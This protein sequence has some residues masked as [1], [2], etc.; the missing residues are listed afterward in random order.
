MNR[1]L[2]SG[3]GRD[4][5][6]PTNEDIPGPG[7][8]DINEN[9][10]NPYKNYGFITKTDRFKK[11]STLFTAYI[12]LIH[13]MHLNLS[14]A[15]SF[16]YF[17]YPDL[18]DEN[19]EPYSADR[20]SVAADSRSSIMSV[21]PAK[22]LFVQKSSN[23]AN[24]SSYNQIPVSSTPLSTRYSS[25]N[26]RTGEKRK[27]Y[28]DHINTKSSS[29][30][31]QVESKTNE[32]SKIKRDFDEM[33]KKLILENE[34]RHK[35]QINELDDK[36]SELI[37]IQS[38]EL[39]DKDTKINELLS[40]LA[41]YEDEIELLSNELDI[42][43]DSAN[44]VAG[45]LE[46]LRSDYTITTRSLESKNSKVEELESQVG[47]LEAR[48]NELSRLLDTSK[49]ENQSL[50][51]QL[52][53][54]T[55]QLSSTK[56]SLDSALAD[57]KDCNNQLSSLRNK[58]LETENSLSSSMSETVTLK[59]QLYASKSDLINTDSQLANTKSDLEA[60][61]S[62]LNATKNLLICTNNELESLKVELSSTSSQLDSAESELTA[63]KYDISTAHSNIEIK[64]NE[65]QTTKSQLISTESQLQN[66]LLEH[67]NTVSKLNKAIESA[68]NEK[69]Q[70]IA[71]KDL[72][73][74]SE[75]ESLKT[76]ISMLK[77]KALKDIESLNKQ[78]KLLLESNIQEL[79]LKFQAEKLAS[80][81][82]F[83]EKI[84]TLQELCSA[85]NDSL[86]KANK[87]YSA[88]L[89][90][91]SK[92]TSILNSYI[93]NCLL[94]TDPSKSSQFNHTPFKNTSIDWPSSPAINFEN[95]DLTDKN[96]AEVSR[97]FT[98][99]KSKVS[100]FINNYKSALDSLFA[101]QTKNSEIQKK[102]DFEVG[103]SKNLEKKLLDSNQKI[104][105]L[106]SEISTLTSNEQKMSASIGDS[107]YK[108]LNLESELV[109]SKNLVQSLQAKFDDSSLKIER[110]ENDLTQ[111]I[112]ESHELKSKLS[113]AAIEIS[114]DQEFISNFK[115][116]NESSQVIIKNLELKIANLERDYQQA[117]LIF[118]EK[119][120][121]LKNDTDQTLND[122]ELL[123]KE[124]DLQIHT[125]R[126]NYNSVNDDLSHALKLKLEAEAESRDL[127]ASLNDK[128][129]DKIN[130]YKTSI[131]DLNRELIAKSNQISEIEAELLR[132]KSAF[133]NYTSLILNEDLKFSEHDVTTM[134]VEDSMELIFDQINQL[135]RFKSLASEYKSISIDAI[136]Q[137]DLVKSS[138]VDL[139]NLLDVAK[140]DM[141]SMV[142][143]IKSQQRHHD[144][145]TA[146]SLKSS[147]GSNSYASEINL[148]VKCM[149]YQL[150]FL[151]LKYP[152]V[153]VELVDSVFKFSTSC[154]LD[155]VFLDFPETTQIMHSTC[156][157]H[158]GWEKVL[159]SFEKLIPSSIGLTTNDILR[160]HLDILLNMIKIDIDETL[161]QQ[162]ELLQQTSALPQP[163]APNSSKLLATSS[164]SSNSGSSKF[165]TAAKNGIN[166]N[167]SESSS[168][169]GR[170]ID[171]VQNLRDKNVQLGSTN[172]LLKLKTVQLA[173]KLSNLEREFLSYKEVLF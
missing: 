67:S 150:V 5:F 77:K 91:I 11:G 157:D 106:E 60:A 93:D 155:K 120:T 128:H 173:A 69:D 94:A 8:Y 20:E 126:K 12:Y 159:A 169:P 89:V 115:K 34:E 79:S 16:L 165:L 168:K 31:K 21:R 3:I 134:D 131:S 32:L 54:S 68:K 55:S 132:F 164:N 102:L 172:N 29:I 140:T 130:S 85:T 14:T 19:G 82:N 57:L 26:L 9:S 42:Q 151:K 114:K 141:E 154:G 65:L 18:I 163:S 59:Q 40:N 88:Q 111:S 58:L 101:E 99:L 44:K 162:N 56:I 98:S 4:V 148:L 113:S 142:S 144:Q 109:D 83:T 143:T 129:Q 146:S 52:A 95:I 170:K 171:Y 105:K 61:L 6:Q 121:S 136:D 50:A 1:K 153:Y 22:R 127:I 46:A 25:M 161:E 76:E 149:N 72:I 53:D 124:R 84:D 2:A 39:G 166:S 133:K 156:F 24:G 90:S 74:A 158:F 28:L 66:L 139:R 23:Q 10:E 75:I 36:Y 64:E 108:L 137:L 7:Q 117:N 119:I 62:D 118:S 63:A 125:L 160:V 48:T 104:V 81:K 47:S 138:N 107:N 38:K 73:N 78:S 17:Y 92:N 167:K 70:L 122:L 15:N 96:Y 97:Y 80:D 30:V 135:S 145:S 35:R 123:I 37:S 87:K 27:R 41:S 147:D 110:L 112:K 100:S 86:S 13:S 71:E 45:E 33:N 51:S 43:T 49:S 103:A 116:Q 152:D